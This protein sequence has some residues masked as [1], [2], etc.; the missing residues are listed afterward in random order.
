MISRDALGDRYFSLRLLDGGHVVI[1]D[2]AS[3]LRGVFRILR[4]WVRRTRRGHYDNLPW[5][6][7]R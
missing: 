7:R 2:N 3:L 5:E 4:A 1:R 6:P